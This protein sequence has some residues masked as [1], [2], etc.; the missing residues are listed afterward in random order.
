MLNNNFDKGVSIIEAL[1]AT[2]ILGVIA[3]FFINSSTIFIGSQQAFVDQSRKDQ[4][5]D[6]IL[7]DIMEYVKI[8]NSPYGTIIADAQ[9][10]SSSTSISV[11]GF[12][13]DPKVGDIF[14]VDG[15]RKGH[16]LSELKTVS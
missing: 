6:L 2:F 5:A 12:S 8:Q 16:Q 4:M 15:L 13:T 7:Q 3:L 1:L 14:L 11:S 9:T 10:F